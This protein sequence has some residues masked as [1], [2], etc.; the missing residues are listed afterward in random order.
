MTT[1]LHFQNFKKNN[2]NTAFYV[3]KG[4]TFL[5]IIFSFFES[6][7]QQNENITLD[8]YSSYFVN[9]NTLGRTP[10]GGDTIFISSDRVKPLKFESLIG[11]PDNPIVVINKDGQVKIDGRIDNVWGALTFE[12]C[13]YIKVSGKGHPGYK[14]GFELA[15]VTSGLSFSEFSSDCE[16]ENIKISHDG[17]FGIHAIKIFNGNPPNPIPVFDNLNVHDCFI[18]NVSEGMYFGETKSPGLEFKNLTIY[19]NIVRNTQRES[20]QIANATENVEIYNNTLINAG[21]EGKDFHMNNLQIGDNS[22]ASI[23][24]N[25]IIQAPDFGIISFGKG[26][27]N[28]F[29]NY[30]ESNTGLFM[31]NRIIS[32]S[33]LVNELSN[34]YFKN[35]TGGEVVRNMNELNDFVATDNVFDSNIPFYTDLTGVDNEVLSNNTIGSVAGIQ[36]TDPTTNDYSLAAGTADEYL[37]M[38]A[39]GGPEFFPYDDP[40]TTPG[41]IVITPEMVTDNVANGSAFSPLFL[42]DE[43]GVDIDA[44]QHPTSLSWKPFYFMD[45]LSYHATVDLGDEYY[46]SQINLHDMHSNFDFVVEYYNGSNWVMVITDPCDSFNQWV[47]EDT[48]IST[49]YLR[50]SMYESPYAAVNE[51]LIYGYPAVKES[52]QIIIN[53]SMVTD[54]VDG[55]SAV[56]PNFLF[57]QQDVDLESNENAVG[58]SW[59]PFY[60]NLKAP[61]HAVV[62]L[63]QEYRLSEIAFHDMHSTNDLVVETSK[64]GENW[65]VLFEEPCDGFNVWQ[66]SNV[67]VVTKYLRFTMLDSPYAA[68]NEVLVFGFPIMTL[69]EINA[70]TINQII[71]TPDMINDLVPGGSVDSPEYLFD[72]QET[73]NPMLDEHPISQ[74]WRPFYNN[75]NAPY[76]VAIDFGM[77]YRITKIYIHDTHSTHNFEVGYDDNSSWNHLFTEPC[78]SF[79]VW[80]V[81]D[82]DVTTSKLRLSMLDSPYAGVNEIII[83]GYPV[84]SGINNK[85][86]FNNS[87]P[88]QESKV[89]S[90]R[91]K[92]ILYPNPVRDHLNLKLPELADS[93][94]QN[95]KIFDVSGNL[96]YNKDV[97]KNNF[98]STLTINTDQIIR[99]P[100]L[101]ILRYRNDKGVQETI[102][103]YKRS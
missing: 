7:A 73:V 58:L 69:S 41:R 37:T 32:D 39:P 60:N 71:V 10:I 95:I 68:V 57:D 103:F 55:G 17:F 99:A 1:H 43:Q 48:N 4:L 13:R 46:I 53:S 20:I 52:Q 51:V 74:N 82:V 44:D 24:N 91:L 86:G 38:G 67:N 25:I 78:D 49:R 84:S 89:I 23:Y 35:L 22:V 87:N 6:I 11:S 29:N 70:L 30:L 94:Q 100:G 42:F 66:I 5:F 40:A 81:H 61:Y 79:N 65:T 97:K 93:A 77:V 18:E 96:I 63:D 27:L 8:S 92:P 54:M 19:N 75:G 76:H 85:S 62:E 28:I 47:R 45:E 59:R 16:A 31:D 9:S 88:Q 80:K 101:Y 36:F 34:N 15:A 14:Y 3:L 98:N 56:S 33:T 2:V 83:F 90:K 21:L 26:D 72:E 50:F 12:N 102:K 64:D